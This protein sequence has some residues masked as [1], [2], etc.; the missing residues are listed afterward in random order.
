MLFTKDEVRQAL[1]DN[2]AK[3]TH[4]QR[5]VM[6]LR[7]GLYG[8]RMITPE[9]IAQK[10]KMSIFKVYDLEREGISV[11]RLGSNRYPKH[12]SPTSTKG[13]DN[14]VRLALV[15]LYVERQEQGLDLY[16]GEKIGHRWEE[17]SDED[18]SREYEDG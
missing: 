16:T 18:G 10:L 9:R 2:G 17:F 7:Y 12:K 13:P 1:E 5:Y 3:L 4:L 6:E 14:P 15:E 8:N 11:I